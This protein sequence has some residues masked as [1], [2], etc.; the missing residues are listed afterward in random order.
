MRISKQFFL[1]L[2]LLVSFGSC[3]S[4]S[5]IEEGLSPDV[6]QNSIPNFDWETAD[7]MPTPVNQSR[8]SVPWV[9]QGS[10]AGI[11][12]IDVVN[13]RRKS[14]GWELLYNT[15]DPNAT[16]PLTNPY[17]VLYNKYRGIMRIYL[18]V[19]TP[20]VTASSYIQD[21]ISIVSNHKSTLLSYLGQEIVDVDKEPVKQY[22]QM[23]QAP[24]D[25]SLPLAANRWYMMQYEL[26]YD[27]N[28]SNIPCNEMQL[29]WTLNYYNVQQISLGGKMEGTLNGTIGSSSNPDFFSPLV[30]IGKTVG[31]GVLAG[32]G[33]NFITKN[34]VNKST[35]EN[36]LGLPKQ[37]FAGLAKGGSSALSAAAGNL[38]GAIMGLFSAII[39]GSKET[40]ISLTMKADIELSGTG[41]E[42]GAFPSTPTSFWIP[43]TKIISDVS[44]YMPLYNKSLGVL[45][46][47][48]KPKMIIDR[49]DEEDHW[50]LDPQYGEDMIEEAYY[51]CFIPDFDYS[52]LLVF[53]PE[54]LSIAE[55]KVL[56]Q[57]LISD[58][59]AIPT[60]WTGCGWDSGG[61]WGG[62]RGPTTGQLSVRFLISVAPKDGSPQ[63]I[64]IKT[65]SIA[66]IYEDYMGWGESISY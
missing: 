39:G 34:T 54:V 58:G 65:F 57:D 20:F 8:I 56:Q 61:P 10:I 40:P 27:P 5:D 32:V 15:F 64:L 37:I 48:E 55:V 19:T 12:G 23:Q 50:M 36:K 29:S 2:S 33:Q 45:Y 22:V 26:A 62:D 21:G 43:G 59:V 18:Y 35:G 24:I 25:G 38:P 14:D 17:F 7:W 4:N 13:D 51:S 42:G 6:P 44:G 11:Y 49:Y 60:G 47:R 46:L 41:T 66:T 16:A 9:G 3:S 53:N 30:G 28:L 1:L 52:N 31:T 63:S